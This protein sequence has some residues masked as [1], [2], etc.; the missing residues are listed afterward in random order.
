MTR[1]RNLNRT[2]LPG[3]LLSALLAMASARTQADPPSDAPL[4]PGWNE[5]NIEAFAA[6]CAQGIIDPAQRDY[7]VAARQ[8]GDTDPKPFPEAEVRASVLP[9]CRC[10]A[11]RIPNTILSATSAS[12][13]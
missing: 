7:A 13:H 5:A 12:T 2:Y 8:A 1:L 4:K 9:M 3:C 6:G 11:V 10:L